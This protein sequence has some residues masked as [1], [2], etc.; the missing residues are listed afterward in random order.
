MPFLTVCLVTF[1]SGRVIEP[2]L[3]ALRNA[4]RSTHITYELR[5]V[6]NASQD[7]TVDQ[8]QRLWPG[9]SIIVN[10]EN[11][12]YA[13]AINQA[14][15]SSQAEWL[16]FLNPDTLVSTDI[17]VMLQ[18]IHALGDVSIFSPLLVDSQR[19]P[20]RTAYKWPTLT[21]ELVRLFGLAGILR[22]ALP[23]IQNALPSRARFTFPKP[24]G[25]GLMVDYVAG[26]CLFIRR[27]TWTTVGPFDEHFFLYHEE[28]E[29]C[30]RARQ[31]GVQ[32]FVIPAIRAVH[33]VKQSSRGRPSEVL[34]WKYQGLLYFYKKH[35]SLAKQLLLRGGMFIAFGARMIVAKVFHLKE[36]RIYATIVWSAIRYRVIT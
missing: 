27:S 28:M 35:H 4:L 12:G 20:I 2:C 8:I 14:A 10:P 9:A 25:K 3:R 24:I 11:Y 18:H 23:S 1:N 31:K 29:W 30:W 6:D 7:D 32:V 5:I 16:L 34:V 13:R 22:R 15:A 17:F 36:A 33:L 26:A 19:K 21:K